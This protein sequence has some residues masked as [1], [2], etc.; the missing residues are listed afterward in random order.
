[1]SI[2]VLRSIHGKDLPS[3]L[4]AF[5]YSSRIE[6]PMGTETVNAAIE[7]IATNKPVSL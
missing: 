1:M 2:E 6:V 3:W 4:F 7:A 5:W